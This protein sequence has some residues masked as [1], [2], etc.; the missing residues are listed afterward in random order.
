MKTPAKPRDLRQKRI[1]TVTQ[2]H[3]LMDRGDFERCI[4]AGWL[5]PCAHFPT[6]KG[7]TARYTLAAVERCEERIAN[8][9]VP[10]PLA[11]TLKKGAPA[12]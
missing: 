7:R 1:L 2:C 3:K 11:G 5:T 6:E 12:A 9:E 4:R 10:E 8:G